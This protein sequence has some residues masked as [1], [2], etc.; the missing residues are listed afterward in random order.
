M[1][2][3]RFFFE[4]TG[5]NSLKDFEE[6]CGNYN[7]NTGDLNCR[8][9]RRDVGNVLLLEATERFQIEHTELDQ[10]PMTEQR[11]ERVGEKILRREHRCVYVIFIIDQ[12]WS[13]I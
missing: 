3:S 9:E 8:V 6:G 1:K 10:G 12:E 11:K 7:F 5:K 4:D 2:G 13:S